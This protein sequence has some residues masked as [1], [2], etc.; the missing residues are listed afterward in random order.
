MPRFHRS[1]RGRYRTEEPDAPPA[2]CEVDAGQRAVGVGG[3]GNGMLCS[4]PSVNVVEVGPE[5]VEIRRAEERAERTPDDA[6]GFRQVMLRER[7]RFLEHLSLR[8]DRHLPGAR[9][10]SRGQ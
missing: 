8:L 7:P 6:L 9:S 2:G 1:G 3:E 4:E 10:V 5:G